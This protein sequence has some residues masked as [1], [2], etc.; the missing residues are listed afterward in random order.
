MITST[1]ITLI[2]CIIAIVASRRMEMIPE[3]F[4]QNSIE[5]G[6]GTLHN[7][8][9]D[10]M[11]E[12]ACKQYFPIIGT[13]F[14][15]I[16]ICNY[17]GLL[18]LAGTLPGLEPPTSSIN[19]PMAL[20]VLVFFLTQY[21]GIK[22]NRG[23]KFFLHVFKPLAFIFPLMIMEQLVRPISLTVRLYGS[24]Y[25]E[26][27]VVHAFFDI[28]PIG[29]PVIM[30][31]LSILMGLVQALVFALLSAIYISEAVETADHL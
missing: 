28:L 13:L 4:L 31:F 30:Q 21:A 20:A 6:I 2:I 25:G 29:L 22:A 15:Y 7:F 23:P 16:L 17:S 8:F 9:N 26:E 10:L 19:F 12:K 1:V 14:I 18:P 24:T 27:A 3:G 5:L 11:G